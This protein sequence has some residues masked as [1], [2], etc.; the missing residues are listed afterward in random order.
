M[1]YIGLAGCL[2]AL[3]CL[4][5]SLFAQNASVSGKVVDPQNASVSAAVVTLLNTDTKVK[6]ESVTNGKGDFLLPPVTPGHYE[7]KTVATGFAP[8]LLTDITLEVGES[9]VES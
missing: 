1:R 3:N 4:A 8:S 2:F 7:A 9:K 6:V 5:S